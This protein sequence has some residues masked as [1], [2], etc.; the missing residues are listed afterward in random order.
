VHGTLRHLHTGN[1]SAG[2]TLDR[3]RLNELV[4]QIAFAGRRGRVYRRIVALS[5][6]RPGDSVLDVGSSS[7]YLARKLAAVAGPE[8]HVT[9][10]DP[11]QAAIAYAQQR[12]LPAMTFTVGTAQRLELPDSSFDVVTCTLAMHHVPARKRAAAVSE[13]YRV[14]RPGGRLLIADFD[15]TRPVLPLHPGG[16]RTRGAAATVGPLEDLA[17]AAGYRVQ[18]CGRLPLLRYVQ[19]IRP[20]GGQPFSDVI[21]P[22]CPESQSPRP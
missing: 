12:A 22:R 6:V 20:A 10:V 4:S 15:P 16:R 17:A 14:T 7:G 19:A 13:M 9:G 21:R 18:S 2:T 5:G 11:A 3:F 1:R 8:G